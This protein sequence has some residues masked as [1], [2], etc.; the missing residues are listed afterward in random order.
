MRPTTRFEATTLVTIVL[1]LS[2]RGCI[3]DTAEASPP[4]EQLD[5]DG[6]ARGS[7]GGAAEDAAADADATAPVPEEPPVSVPYENPV[8][9]IDFPDPTVIRGVDRKF[10]AFATGGR[11]QRAVSSD[12]VHWK[13]I[14][15]A[16]AAKPTWASMKNA[17]WAPHVVE[18]GGTYYLYFSAER[19]AGTGSFCIGVATAKGPEQPFVDAGKPVVCG[20][21]FVHI[22]PMAYDDPVTKKRLLYWGSGFEAVRVQELAPDRLALAPGSQAIPLLVPSKKSYERLVEAGW[23]HKRGDWY[24]LFSSG[25]DCC[26]GPNGPPHYAVL[27]ARSKSATGPF[28]DYGAVTGRADNTIL[29]GDSRWLGPGHNAVVTD[30]AGTDWMVYHSFDKTKAGGR[31]M[32]IDPIVYVDGWP[33]IAGRVPSQGKQDGPMIR[34]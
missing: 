6:G 7:D 20:P 13:T 8:L 24:Y 17:F 25:D 4:T 15:N 12:L 18:H 16:L 28:E 21:S 2:S 30:D 32:L 26:G 22:D 3:T 9:A 29:V 23:L 34:P 10:Y 11:I 1:A 31:F 27:A 5:G 33:T 19:N 14:D